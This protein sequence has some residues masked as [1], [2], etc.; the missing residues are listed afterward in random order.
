MNSSDSAFE[1]PG[2]LVGSFVLQLVSWANKAFAVVSLICR[3]SDGE[4]SLASRF[5]W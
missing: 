1:G 5:W 3:G 2:L 4:I